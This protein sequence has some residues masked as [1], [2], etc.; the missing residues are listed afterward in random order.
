MPAFARL[1]MP[2]ATK[3]G[4]RG[5]RTERYLDGALEAIEAH[6][7]HNAQAYVPGLILL[8]Q[9]FDEVVP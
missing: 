6:A 2:F 4:G 7:S 3:W 8:R 5:D 9:E 1:I